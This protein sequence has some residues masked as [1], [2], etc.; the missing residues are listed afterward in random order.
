MKIF[1]LLF[2][3]IVYLQLYAQVGIDNPAPDSSS[4]LDLRSTTQGFL[5]PRMTSAQRNS[6]QT[7]ANSLLVFDTDLNKFMFWDDNRNQWAMLNPWYSEE[8]GI[9]RYSSANNDFKINIAPSGGHNIF[10][11]YT[12]FNGVTSDSTK[13]QTAFLFQDN[14]ISNSGVMFN[15][16]VS[17]GKFIIMR[18]IYNSSPLMTINSDGNWG[19]GYTN[20]TKKMEVNGEIKASEKISADKFTGKGIAPVGSIVMWS[21][22][23]SSIPSG[24]V[25]CDGNNGTPNLKNRFVVGAGDEYS[26]GSTGGTNSVTLTINQMPA[27]NHTGSTNTAGSHTHKVVKSSS[28]DNGS[29]SIA[30]KSSDGNY[31]EYDLFSSSSTANWGETDSDGSHSH[32]LIM[33]NTGGGQAHE[34]RPPYYALAFIM[35]IH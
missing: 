13:Y 3:S 12:S 16:K 27:H 24:W 11:V 21:G 20:P 5:I 23:V 28:D 32:T 33:D 1:I 26:V 8:D 2:L 34:N 22:S 6:I 19:L 4:V 15:A 31:E 17:G 30:W 9:I 18:A 29:L 10:R 7:N 14:L 25:L 35:R